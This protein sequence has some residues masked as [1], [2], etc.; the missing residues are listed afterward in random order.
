[1][2]PSLVLPI[3]MKA[4]EDVCLKA[5]LCDFSNQVMFPTD[6]SENADHAFSYVERLAVQGARRVTL[7][8]VQKH[9]HQVR[10]RESDHPCKEG[11]T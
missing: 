2:K 7:F 1:M 8:H 5:P 6:F 11:M 4:G 10:Y 9:Q 3:E